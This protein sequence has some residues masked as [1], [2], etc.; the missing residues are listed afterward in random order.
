MSNVSRRRLLAGLVSAVGIAAV[1]V[2]LS[3]QVPAA[4]PATPAKAVL[5]GSVEDLAVKFDAWRASRD[6]VVSDSQRD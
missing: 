3:L 5:G 6:F 2:P 4:K 1:A